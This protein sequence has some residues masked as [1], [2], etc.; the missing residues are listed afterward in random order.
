M[1]LFFNKLDFD[2]K[3]LFIILEGIAYTTVLNI[4]SP[5]V[6]MFAK[7]MGAGDFHIALLNSIPPL[8]AVFVLI[9]CSILFEKANRKKHATSLM[10]LLNSIFYA[11]IAF[12]P[13]IPG[14]LKIIVYII[15]IGLMNWP[16]SLYVTTWQSFFADTYSG[17]DA[18]HIFSLRSKY[19]AFFGLLAALIAGLILTEIPGNEAE[20]III[21]QAFYLACFAIALVQLYFLSR[22]RQEPVGSAGHVRPVPAA[23]KLSGF[24]EV[25]HN[26]SFMIFCICT[27]LFHITWQMGWPLFFLYNVD[28]AGLNEFQIGM[29]SVIVGMT[30]FFSYSIWNRLI[31]RKG[32][33]FVII[34]SA[35]GLALN[36]FFFTSLIGFYAIILI[37]IAAGFSGTG[38]SFTLFCS[39]LETL[40]ENKKTFYISFFNTFINISGFISPIIGILLYKQ[41]GIYAAMFIIGL[42][43]LLASSFYI[44]R[45][46]IGKKSTNTIN[47]TLEV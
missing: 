43:R 22:I 38:F 3:A 13:F 6:L 29:I 37:N 34:I 15:L 16:G 11:I 46:L 44:I 27:F 8:V 19:S 26:K 18:N 41:T 1:R 2:N 24:K 10:I 23:F 20:R 25:F 47:N 7:R 30:S 40:P 39:L 4:Y 32:T 35:I 42:L 31:Q 33:K 17:S 28:Y 12:V 36:P 9:P 45:W 21:Y 14:Q 5:F